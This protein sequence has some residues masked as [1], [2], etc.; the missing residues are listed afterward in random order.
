MA[1]SKPKIPMPVSERAKQ[2]SPFSPLKSLSKALAEK[3][4][5][6]VPKREI[7]DEKREEINKALINLKTGEIVTV[8]YYDETEQEYLQLTGMVA[9]VDI[10]K[11]ILQIVAIKIR[12]EDIY[13]IILSDS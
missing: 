8:V 1:K 7:S 13:D 11:S 3:E 9:K 2:F 10:Y 5:I 12:F 4:K 6:R